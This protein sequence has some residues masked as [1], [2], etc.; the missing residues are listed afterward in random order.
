L[1]AA[2]LLDL[3]AGTTVGNPLDTMRDRVVGRSWTM[4]MGAF[5]AGK[6]MLAQRLVHQQEQIL[7][8]VPATELT[9]LNH[10]GGSENEL[11]RSILDYLSAFDNFE[12]LEE[13]DLELLRKMAARILAGL[14]RVKGSPYALVIDGLDE[15]RRYASA[16]GLQLLTNEL[17]RTE[18][19]VILTVRREQFHDHFSEMA[20]GI[21]KVSPS[22]FRSRDHR[23]AVLEL[24]DWTSE[25]VLAY[26]DNAIGKAEA[27]QAERL[28]EFR[29]GVVANAYTSRIYLEHP[30]F[31]AMTVDLVAFDGMA[32][33]EH[34]ASL[35][36]KWAQYKLDRDFSVTRFVPAGFENG[37]LRTERLL[38]LM[39]DV[40]SNMTVLQHDKIE[41]LES[42]GEDALRPLAIARFDGSPVESDIYATT[43]FLEPV[44]RRDTRR[45]AF[46]FFHRSF[47]EY[48]LARHL[49]ESGSD[50]KQYPVS[51]RDFCEE[52][53][54]VSK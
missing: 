43:S 28:A 6:S 48:F 35:Y 21:A 15:N 29:R 40:A 16:Q 46:K 4:I 32:P 26:L 8:Y 18:C 7:I 30:L 50:I 27:S 44:G 22:Q 51:V 38:A 39:E 13:L 10:G 17:A 41:L 9:H 54:A 53:G 37:G 49:V 5:G 19:P 12:G 1:H 23:V 36:L 24:V 47:Q 42:I 33:V 45:T 31:L 25:Q 34:R 14:T 52:I 3:T 11:F 20:P 2:P